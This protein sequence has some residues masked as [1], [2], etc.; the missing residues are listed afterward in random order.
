MFCVQCG[1]QLPDSVKFCPFCGAPASEKQEN[2][3]QTDTKDPVYKWD[4]RCMHAVLW[5]LGAFLIVVLAASIIS[6]APA[7]TAVASSG[8]ATASVPKESD[9]PYKRD[10]I[11][12]NKVTAT[13]VKKPEDISV[14]RDAL[15]NKDEAALQAML[16]QGKFYLID[17]GTK[18]QIMEDYPYIKG[19]AMVMVDSGANIQKTGYVLIAALTK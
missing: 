18:M 17:Q 16:I 5:I 19:Y 9:Y 2:K 6:P 12:Y 13:V 10:D 11:V 4:R 8:K 3:K 15:R 1:H 14:V 7:R